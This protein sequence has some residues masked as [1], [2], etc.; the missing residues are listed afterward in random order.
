MLQ[1]G[2]VPIVEEHSRNWSARARPREPPLRPGA[3][4]ASRCGVR[5]PVRA[6][7]Q[8]DDGSADLSYVEAVAAE[9]APPGRAP[10][11]STSRR[12]VG[13][14]LVSSGCSGAPTCRWCRI[15]SSAR[16]T[17]SRQPPSRADRGRRRRPVGRRRV[18]DLF[19]APG[20]APHH[21]R[22]RRRRSS[23]RPTRSWPQ[24]ELRQRRGEPVRGGRRRRAGRHPRTRLRKRIGF[25]FMSRAGL[26]GSCCQG[27]PA[28]VH[29]AEQAGYDFSFLKGPSPPTT[30]SSS[31]SWPRSG[32]GGTLAGVHA[33]DDRPISRARSSPCGA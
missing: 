31:G 7:P 13:S 4:A 9:I 23:T 5:V 33:G 1:R 19:S 28:L 21:R 14:T 8:G 12:P 11:S 26:G 16:G 27:H 22:A 6:T 10:S 18:G 30:S 17:A 25:E 29:I 20:A 24:A 2:E 3:T 15:P 32:G